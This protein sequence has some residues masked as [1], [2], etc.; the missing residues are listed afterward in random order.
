VGFEPLIKG[1]LIQSFSPIFA[2]AFSSLR[3]VIVV[4]LMGLDK[5]TTCYSQLVIFHGISVLIG[6][7]VAGQYT[8]QCTNSKSAYIEAT[9]SVL[10]ALVTQ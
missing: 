8:S 7:P 6:A 1:S 3:S 2:A 9:N 5:L 10:L 4:E